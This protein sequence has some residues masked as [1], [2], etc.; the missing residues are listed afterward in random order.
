MSD[1]FD[2]EATVDDVYDDDDDDDEIASVSN[3]DI[4]FIDDQTYTDDNLE[5][6]YAFT[7]VSRS[8]E[9]AMQDSFLNPDSNESPTDA[10]AAAEANY[11]YDNYDPVQDEIDEFRDSTTRVEEFKHTLFCRQG[12]QNPD[13]FYYAIL[14]DLRHKNKNCKDTCD[15]DD[16]L[17]R[18]IENDK[19][20]EALSKAKV[21]L[22]L[23]LDIQ[24]FENQ[25]YLV[26]SLLNENNLFL[27]VH[28]LKDKF[29]YF[30]RQDVN[31][32]IILRELSAFVIEKF[33]GFHIV[34]T[35]FD[36]KLRRPFRPVDYAVVKKND[37][38]DNCFLREK[39]NLAFRVSCSEGQK[40]AKFKHL[41][42]GTVT[43]SQITT[44]A[45]IDLS[46]TK[47]IQ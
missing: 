36:N 15:S 4:N 35:D 47:N 8:V 34:R 16:Q 46:N 33:N 27:I 13:S 42:H 21:N 10:G 11:C 24:N 37:Q 44:L 32:K 2:F 7:K 30:I 26:N 5:N 14:Y 28:E 17:K 22:R 41:P 25:C 39:L 31:R 40:S 20:F 29:R 1:F 45:R 12:A 3:N 19:L 38:L 23:D 43:F 6:Y 18:D 9:D